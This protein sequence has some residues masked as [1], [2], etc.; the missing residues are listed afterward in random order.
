MGAIKLY[1]KFIVALCDMSKVVMLEITTT[2]LK[3]ICQL[4]CKNQIQSASITRISATKG[5]FMIIGSQIQLFKV[6]KDRK[7][8]RM[9]GTIE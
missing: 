5:Y 8:V 7:H 2:G 9:V 3:E 4:D 1:P 6:D